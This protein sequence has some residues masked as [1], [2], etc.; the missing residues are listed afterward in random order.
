MTLNDPHELGAMAAW[1]NID[2]RLAILLPS[3]CWTSY[4]TMRDKVQG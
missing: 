2:G 4:K 3:Q 1:D